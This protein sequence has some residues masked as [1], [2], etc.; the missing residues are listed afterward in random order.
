MASADPPVHGSHRRS[1]STRSEKEAKQPK[2]PQDSST[3]TAQVQG[4]ARKME[5][6][7]AKVRLH[8]PNESTTP[9]EPR[10]GHK[11]A[12]HMK[13]RS[14]ATRRIEDGGVPRSLLQRSDSPGELVSQYRIVRG[15]DRE[16]PQRHT[17]GQPRYTEL[18][19]CPHGET[20]ARVLRWFQ[21]KTAGGRDESPVGRVKL[22]SP[23][24]RGATRKSSGGRT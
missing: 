5:K 11:K 3:D 18:G 22:A 16:S 21:A 7:N 19:G 20:K 9:S 12:T 1:T 23:Q 15:G 2:P 13:Q 6:R 4:P 24:I 17:G 10:T 14:E 8:G